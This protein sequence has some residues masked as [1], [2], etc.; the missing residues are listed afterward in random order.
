MTSWMVRFT[1]LALLALAVLA[2]PR[3]AAEPS[4]AGVGDVKVLL[5]DPSLREFKKVDAK[6]LTFGA[7]TVIAQGVNAHFDGPVPVPVK[8]TSQGK[9]VES[10]RSTVYPDPGGETPA[11]RR[12][13]PSC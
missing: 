4:G 13:T 9:D 8:V 6:T 10:R 11:V 5:F 7:L 3:A 2:G 12:L 1:V